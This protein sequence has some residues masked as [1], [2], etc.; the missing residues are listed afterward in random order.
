MLDDLRLVDRVDQRLSRKVY[1]RFLNVRLDQLPKSVGSL[2]A[3]MR[4]YESVRGFITGII[5]TVLIDLPFALIFVVI[6]YMIA[7]WPA[8]IPLTFTIICMLVGY[9]YH[10][11]IDRLAGNA[12]AA[13]NFKMGLLVESVEGAETIKSG[14]GGGRIDA[15][16]TNGKP[17]GGRG[18]SKPNRYR[19]VDHWLTDHV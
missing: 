2:A 15:D 19:S 6:I 18:S 12:N 1:L 11:K 10:N 9:Y 16:F 3:Q 17:I 7:G 8:F 13:S 14:Q 5:G 4:G